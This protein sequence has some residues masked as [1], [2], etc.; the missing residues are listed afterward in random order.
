MC[1]KRLAK[2]YLPPGGCLFGSR[3]CYNLTY[4]SQKQHDKNVT[5]LLKNP[6]MMR[7]LEKRIDAGDIKACGLVIRA[8]MKGLRNS[9]DCPPAVEGRGSDKR[10]CKTE[11]NCLIVVGAYQ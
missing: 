6:A 9:E 1:Y 2:V 3:K 8:A 4:R 11:N 10:A 5:A 7:L